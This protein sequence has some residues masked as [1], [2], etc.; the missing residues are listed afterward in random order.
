MTKKAKPVGPPP[1]FSNRGVLR[2]VPYNELVIDAN[3]QREYKPGWA[4]HIAE[5]MDADMFEPIKVARR[6]NGRFYIF[7]GQHR[8]HALGLLGYTSKH[9]VQCLVFESSGGRDEGDR[10]LIS[11]TTKPVSALC[12]FRIAVNTGHEDECA[13]SKTIT[14]LGLKV[15]SGQSP[16][17]V[18][19]VGVCLTIYRHKNGGIHGLK[20]VLR[21]ARDAWEG[22]ASAFDEMTL[23]A[24]NHVRVTI[25][26]AGSL[27]AAFADRIGRHKINQI[28]AEAKLKTRGIVGRP[29]H[30]EMAAILVDL[31]NQGLSDK[32]RLRK[33]A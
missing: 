22:E 26:D 23:K 1:E 32:R 4:R 13:V 20:E 6:P 18:R 21:C 9:T 33:S 12:K 5:N 28:I 2:D 17:R 27:P 31:Y 8:Y 3:Y 25:G 15:G 16:M 10:F 7:D 11:N 24:L 19:A 29:S 14:D 30:I